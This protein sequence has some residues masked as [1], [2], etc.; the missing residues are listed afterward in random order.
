[1]ED[2]HWADASTPELLHLLDQV[3]TARV[4][5]LLTFR[6]ELMPWGARPMW[7]R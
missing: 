3:P 4:L 6:P 5:V 1:M 2:L 7:R